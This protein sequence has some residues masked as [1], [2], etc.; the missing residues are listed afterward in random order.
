MD[1]PC[2]APSAPSD[3]RTFTSSPK[4]SFHLSV[5]PPRRPG[6]APS[7][8]PVPVRSPLLDAARER[9]TARGL[10]RPAAFARRVFPRFAHAA[11][12]HPFSWLSRAPASERTHLRARSSVVGHFCGLQFGAVMNKAAVNTYTWDLR[13]HVFRSLAH[14]PKSRMAGSHNNCSTFWGM[15]NSLPGR[16]RLFT[17][18]PAGG[19]G[20][21]FSTSSPTLVCL[22]CSGRRAR[23]GLVF[24]RWPPVPGGL[25]CASRLL[26]FL[27]GEMS[28]R[29][30]GP[31]L[32]GLFFSCWV[33]GVISVFQILAPFWYVIC[34]Y[35]FAFYGSLFHFFGGC[36]LHTE[37]FSIWIKS[38]LPI[39]NCLAFGILLY[40]NFFHVNFSESPYLVLKLLLVFL[41]EWID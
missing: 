12:L 23:P 34:K 2:R 20:S 18:P 10:S 16:L 14:V 31:F 4:G 7:L 1:S 25:L 3:S 27:F 21:S 5:I 39:F 15:P 6:E 9:E 8:L 30:F 19:R 36:P 29:I 22:F 35:F 13:E 37:D 32:I 33:A 24:P 26:C 40:I 17:F 41:V 11:T 28:A 38:N